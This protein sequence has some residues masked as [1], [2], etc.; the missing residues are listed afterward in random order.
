M[1]VASGKVYE[2]V[3]APSCFIQGVSE[4]AIFANNIVY[5]ISKTNT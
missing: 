4:D 3:R 5:Y 2:R 1:S